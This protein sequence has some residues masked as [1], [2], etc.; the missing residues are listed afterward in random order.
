MESK[1]VAII[2]AG[3]SGLVAANV[4]LKDGFNVTIFERGRYIGGMW[5]EDNIYINLHSQQFGG[6]IE[7]SDL[8]DGE[9][10]D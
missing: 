2:G 6:T 3:S 4:L 10:K 7:F 8:F 9:G 5:C 1:S